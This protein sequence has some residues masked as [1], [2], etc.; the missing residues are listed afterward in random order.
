MWRV[1]RGA[2]EA[3]EKALIHSP[4]AIVLINLFNT[5]NRSP[6]SDCQAVM[7]FV[8]PVVILP[9]HKQQTEPVI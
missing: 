1:K 2:E 6:Q 4:E 7:S 3:K 8:S 9:S 5:N